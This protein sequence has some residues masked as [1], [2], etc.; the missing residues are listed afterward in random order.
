M[1]LKDYPRPP[2][3][4]GRGLHWSS[5]QYAW[6]RDEWEL[7]SQ[8]LLDMK[9]K[10]VTVICPADSNAN[11]LCKRLID[12][13]I[14]PVVRFMGNKEPTVAGGGI[15]AKVEDL[16]ALGVRY[17]QLKN[18]NDAAVERE[19]GVPAVHVVQ[20]RHDPNQNDGQR[21]RNVAEPGCAEHLF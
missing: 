2:S 8:R 11:E 9:I 4:N 18:E 6:G 14:M 12:L 1:E 16:I 19:G 13:E 15:M 10:W 5:A 17:F 21:L 20:D 7:W 3:D